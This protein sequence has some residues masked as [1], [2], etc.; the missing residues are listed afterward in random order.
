MQLGQQ[1]CPEFTCSN[2]L[3]MS[4]V[5]RCDFVNDC[6]DGSDEFG[7]GKSLTDSTKNQNHMLSHELT[8]R[9]LSSYNVSLLQ[10]PYLYKWITSVRPSY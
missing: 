6:G 10:L 8:F 3:C 7:C 4:N 1:S 2:S 9:W 5:R